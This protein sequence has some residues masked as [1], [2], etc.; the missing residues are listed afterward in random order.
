MHGIVIPSQQAQ[1]T[2]AARCGRGTTS[3]GAMPAHAQPL[4]ADLDVAASGGEG[5]ARGLLAASAV[6][7]LIAVALGLGRVGLLMD[8]VAQAVAARRG[9]RAA[10]AW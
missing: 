1:P 2:G 10:V 6:V 3:A 5:T 9:G 7:L 4:A 8:A